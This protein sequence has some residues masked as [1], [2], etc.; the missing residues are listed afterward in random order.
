MGEPRTITAR[1]AHWCHWCGE[2]IEKGTPYESTFIVWE[3][4]PWTRKLHPECAEADRAYDRSDDTLYY[5]G[6]FQRGHAHEPNWSTVAAGISVGCPGCMKL[7]PLSTP[8]LENL[9]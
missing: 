1:K 4:T 9:P 3:G 7:C 2:K 6:Q 5:E 8:T